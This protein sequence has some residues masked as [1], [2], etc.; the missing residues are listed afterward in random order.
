L[1]LQIQETEEKDQE[2]DQEAQPTV[3]KEESKNFTLEKQK[4]SLFSVLRHVL[5]VSLEKFDK[6]TIRDTSKQAWGRLIVNA[7]GT[8][9]KIIETMELEELLQRVQLLEQKEVSKNE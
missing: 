1:A 7:I 2:Q 4:Q 8:Y 3:S 9:G 6:N 5:A